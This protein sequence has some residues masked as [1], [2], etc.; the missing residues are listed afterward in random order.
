MLDVRELGTLQLDALREVASIGS[1]HAATALSQLTGRR[2]WV[3]APEIQIVPVEEVGSLTGSEEEIVACVVMQVL[4]DLAGRT[5]QVFPDATASRLAG[6]L[7][8]RND[9]KFPDGFGEVEKSALKEAGNIIGAAYLNA[10]SD[11]LGMIILTSVPGL[12][13]DQAGAVLTSSSIMEAD[14]GDHLICIETTFRMDEERQA[15]KGHFLLVPDPDSL[16]VI[17][18]AIRLA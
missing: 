15:L 13:I 1:G 11:F 4:G 5:I 9:V 2:I 17:L 16:Q 7:L 12:A 6:I 10:L 8:R 18:R 14:H 3:N